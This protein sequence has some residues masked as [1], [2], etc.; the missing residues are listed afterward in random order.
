VELPVLLTV[1]VEVL[2]W[3]SN[4]VAAMLAV[5]GLHLRKELI[6][7]KTRKPTVTWLPSLALPVFHRCSMNDNSI[8]SSTSASDYIGIRWSVAAAAVVN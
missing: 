3:L 4:A 8:V 7:T 1:V 5:V 2:Q 6:A